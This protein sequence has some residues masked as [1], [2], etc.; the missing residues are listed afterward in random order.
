MDL[1][2]NAARASSKLFTNRYSSSFSLASR[3]YAPDIRTDIYAVY[4]LTRVA[5]EIVDS[6]HGPYAAD[7]LHEYEQEIY[8][9]LQRGY[10]PNPII[11]AF[12]ATANDCAIDAQL[13]QPF[14]ES[15]ATDLSSH[16]FD[17]DSY[18]RYI[19]GSAEVI[20]LMCLKIFC[21]GNA[22]DYQQLQAGAAYQKINFLRDM[23]DDYHKLGRYYFPVDDYVTFNDS[24]KQ[25]IIQDIQADF[26][27]AVPAMT[28]LP[29]SARRAVWT[30]Y[31]YYNVLLKKLERADVATL[32]S[33]R[34]RLS[35]AHKLYLL[36]LP[37]TLQA[38]R[39]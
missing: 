31:R 20:G 11:H 12:Q 18:R 26:S 19:Y 34:L 25:L 32:K 15:M 4:G 21:A 38:G 36:C 30:S 37:L 28:Q 1:Y 16:S 9:A 10:S 2:L 39:P 27:Q 6:Y 5:D 3:L 33:R 13:L 24:T 7:M 22:S 17:N 35:T 23:A 29:T 8:R 14:F